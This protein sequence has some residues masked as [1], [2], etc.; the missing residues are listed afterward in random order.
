MVNVAPLAMVILRQKAPAALIVGEKVVPE[1]II[2]SVVEVGIA[3]HQF[4][5]VAQSELVDP[6]QYPAPAHPVAMVTSPVEVDKN[7]VSS[8][9]VAC[10]ELVPP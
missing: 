8:L 6:T 4:D 2:T 9:M 7:R 5:A 3:P 1:G 10:V